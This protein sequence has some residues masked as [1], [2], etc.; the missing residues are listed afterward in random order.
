MRGMACEKKTESDT[1]PLPN[2]YALLGT[3]HQSQNERYGV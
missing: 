1:V 3:E 2:N